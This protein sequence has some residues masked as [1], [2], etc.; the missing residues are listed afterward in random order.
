MNQRSARRIDLKTKKSMMLSQKGS[1]L[2]Q[3]SLRCRHLNNA[4]DAIGQRGR[5]RQI[6]TANEYN[7]SNIWSSNT[8]FHQTIAL[9]N[10]MNSHPLYKS[11]KGNVLSSN[12]KRNDT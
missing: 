5:A 7:N 10:H 4:H 3:Y 8:T 11:G 9:F 1:A 12:G 2:N 6:I